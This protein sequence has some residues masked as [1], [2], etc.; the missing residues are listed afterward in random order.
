M[1]CIGT[2]AAP[3]VM[4]FPTRGVVSNSDNYVVSF[5]SSGRQIVKRLPDVKTASGNLVAS[6][7]DGIVS[8]VPPYLRLID[9]ESRGVTYLAPRAAQKQDRNA[10]AVAQ[11]S[12]NWLV[13]KHRDF[14]SRLP[15]S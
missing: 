9:F 10:N 5:D 13:S 8:I 14:L 2:S 11:H 7:N 1:V 15:K 12:V 4:Q 3:N 6:A